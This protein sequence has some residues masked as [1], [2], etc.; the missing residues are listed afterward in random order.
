MSQLDFMQKDTC[1]TLDEDDNVIGEA[2]KVAAHQ[3]NK[4]TPRGVLHRAFSVFMFNNKGELLLQ[5]RAADKITFPNVWTNTCCSHPLH[6]YEP[7]EVDTPADLAAGN[8]PG[9]K[10]AAIRKLD[11]ELGIKASA[12]PSQKFKFLTR[13]HYWAADVV[14]HGPQSPWGE[15]EIDYI[16]FI[17][18]QPRLKPNPEEVSAT[19]WV[20]KE[21][22]QKMM[23]PSNGLL[24]S[25]WFRII[26]EQFLIPHWWEDLEATL[27]TD[28]FVDTK[29]IHRF[30]PTEEHMGGAGHAGEWLGA[31]SAPYAANGTNNR[32]KPRDIAGLTTANGDAGSKQGAYGKVKIHKHS[33]LSQAMRV[34]EV[35]SA[36][37]LMAGYGLNKGPQWA[38]GSDEEFCDKMLGKVSRS[39]A[40]V[41]R[42]LPEGLMMEILIF[43]LVLRALDTI[44]DDM[45][46]FKGREHE[47]IDWLNSFA[48]T[49]LEEEGWKLMGVGEGDER[50]LL[51]SFHR[52]GSVFRSLSPHAKEVISDITQRMGAGMASYV[53]ADLG[54]GTKTVD[55]YDLYCHYVAGLVGEGLS[56]LFTCTGFESPL[57]AS[58]S[59]TLANTMGL[60]LQKTNIIRDYLEDYVDGRAFWP[61]E[62]FV[63]LALPCGID[64]HP[65]SLL[66]LAFHQPLNT[67]RPPPPR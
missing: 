35:F 43:Y 21:E 58:V 49:A 51:E 45:D 52:C 60:F 53:N 46:F 64:P 50:A 67:P 23:D 20:S 42:Q 28:Q 10:L 31:V 38:P 29:T 37:K 14:T 22:L 24:W 55:D 5:Q 33:K 63:C 8:V 27:T 17:R 40:A 12:V 56:R 66:L 36:I 44:E 3:F 6:G 39:F 2:S 18:A 54:Q 41:I 1:I 57:V 48:E 26:A 15:H 9:V 32:S 62:V 59:T 19:K 30:D 34:T 11:Q 13:L 7:T 4:D 16:I 25:P 47:K 65:P 61:Q